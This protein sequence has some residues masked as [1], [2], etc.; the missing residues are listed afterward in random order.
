[1]IPSIIPDAD[2]WWFACGASYKFTENFQW[3]VSFA[4]LHGV[5]ERNLQDSDGNKVGRYR[6]LDAYLLGTQFVYKF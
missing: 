1:M 5:H 2:R 3:D 6:H 4:H